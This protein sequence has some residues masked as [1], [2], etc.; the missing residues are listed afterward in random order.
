MTAEPKAPKCP[1]CGTTM[2]AYHLVMPPSMSGGIEV[3][4]WRWVCVESD[5]KNNGH[6]VEITRRVEE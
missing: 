6:R 2:L 1:V 4:Q 5:G 3:L